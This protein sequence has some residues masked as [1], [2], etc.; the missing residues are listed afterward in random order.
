MD[1]FLKISWNTPMN[2][3]MIWGVKTPIFGLT[4]ISKHLSQFQQLVQA[5]SLGAAKGDILYDWAK[6]FIKR[7]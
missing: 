7:L 3:W 2:K 4:P 5:L 6:G 1:G